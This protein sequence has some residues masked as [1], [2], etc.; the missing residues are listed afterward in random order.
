MAVMEIMTQIH[1]V[2]TEE[3]T[4]EHEFKTYVSEEREIVLFPYMM[5]AL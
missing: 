4:E 1:T 2:L 5:L 3:L